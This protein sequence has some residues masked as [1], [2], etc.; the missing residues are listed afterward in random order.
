MYAKT[1]EEKVNALQI[2]RRCWHWS[3]YDRDTDPPR[4]CQDNEI[5]PARSRHEHLDRS[6]SDQEFFEHDPRSRVR[7]RPATPLERRKACLNPATD[8]GECIRL[9]AR[10]GNSVIGFWLVQMIVEVQKDIYL[11]IFIATD[12]RII[13]FWNEL[14]DADIIPA[15][16]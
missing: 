6:I 2:V 9:C 1:D 7:V 10:F 4:K 16:V 3:A 12:A 8:G 14:E 11:D 13:R 5:A 15:N